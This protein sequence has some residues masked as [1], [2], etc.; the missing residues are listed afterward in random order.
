M[1]IL[2]SDFGTRF[3]HSLSLSHIENLDLSNNALEDR[4]R[5][6]I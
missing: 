3:S 6:M 5:F 4:G 1:N 2:S